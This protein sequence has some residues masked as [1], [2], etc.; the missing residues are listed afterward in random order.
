MQVAVVSPARWSLFR[1]SKQYLSLAF[2]SLGHDVLYVDPPVSVASTV[3]DRDRMRDLRGPRMEAAATGLRVWHPVVAPGQNSHLGQRLNAALLRRGIT[4]AL[5]HL[6]LTVAFSLE[7]RTVLPSLSGTRVYYCTDSFE[8]LPGSDAAQLR[9]WEGE[10]IGGADVVVGCS[11][12]LCE[13][14]AARGAQPV[15]LPHAT[16][17]DALTEPGPMP[18]E[19][20][21]LPRPLVAYLGSLNFRIDHTLLEAAR[22]G[23]GDGTVVIIGDDYGPRMDP[24]S[25]ALLR[26]PNVV[27]I[28]HRP[29]HQ[30]STYLAAVDVGIVPYSPAPFNRKSFPIKVLQYLAAGL[31]VVSSSNGATDELGDAVSVADDPGAFADAVRRSAA[32]DDAGARRGRRALAASRRWT[33]NAT[34]LIALAETAS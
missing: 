28:G 1:L 12:P 18:A 17:D 23:A 11:L 34:R 8:D 27:A 16:D 10:L 13:Q 19:L 20:A 25:A 30:L 5:P 24:R 4:R 3:R 14:L 9:R 26:A 21:R 7:S 33:D 22:D 6:D 31:P 32:D 15:Y 29:G 2:A